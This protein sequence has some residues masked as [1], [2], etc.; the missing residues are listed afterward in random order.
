MSAACTCLP[1]ER[2]PANSETAVLTALARCKSWI[3]FSNACAPG[4]SARCG[5]DINVFFE[6][7]IL[8][9]ERAY[10]ATSSTAPL[11]GA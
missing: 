7:V 1:R 10:G 4:P 11:S 5:D 8:I 3:D 2:Y 9:Y 6:L